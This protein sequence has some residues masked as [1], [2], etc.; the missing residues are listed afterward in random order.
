MTTPINSGETIQAGNGVATSFTITYPFFEKDDLVVKAQRT[1]DALPLTMVLG[2]DYQIVGTAVDGRFEANA[3]YVEFLEGNQV[4]S[5]VGNPAPPLATAVSITRFTD[6]DQLTNYPNGGLFPAKSHEQALDKLTKLAQEGNRVDTR[7]FK[8]DDIV[9]PIGNT[10]VVPIADQFLAFDSSLNLT[11]KGLTGLGA[12]DLD[13]VAFTGGTIDGVDIGQTTPALGDFTT[14][15]AT[16]SILADIINELT[17]DTGVTVEGV[18]MI[19]GKMTLQSL[20]A[21]PASPSEGCLWYNSTT[22]QYKGYI[23][24]SVVVFSTAGSSTTPTLTTLFPRVSPNLKPDITSDSQITIPAGF[25]IYAD[26]GSAVIQTVSSLVIDLSNPAGNLGLDTGTEAASTAY[27]IYLISG[28]SGVGAIAVVSGNTPVL[29]SGY[30][31]AKAKLPYAAINDADSNLLKQRVVSGWPNNPVIDFADETVSA[32]GIAALATGKTTL[33][34]ASTINLPSTLTV[35]CS[36]LVPTMARSVRLHTGINTDFAGAI[37]LRRFGDTNWT[38][39]PGFPNIVS[40][41]YQT[42][43]EVGL[44][45]SRRFEMSGD[46][47]SSKNLILQG[48]VITENPV[49]S[50]GLVV[51]SDSFGSIQTL[52]ADPVSPDD[53]DVWL[54]TTDNKV[55][56]RV[57]GTTKETIF[58]GDSVSFL[59]IS[60]SDVATTTITASGA[61]NLNG[62]TTIDNLRSASITKPGGSVNIEGIGHSSNYL[63]LAAASDLSG[64]GVNARNVWWNSTDDKPKA[65][66]VTST[67]TFAFESDLY[68]DGYIHGPQPHIIPDTDDNLVTQVRVPNGLTCL[69]DTNSNLITVTANL[70]VDL[71]NPNGALGLD[72]G[73]LAANQHRYLWLCEGTSGVT[74][75]LS[76]SDTSPTLPTGYTTRKRRLPFPVQGADASNLRNQE[77]VHGWPYTPYIRLRDRAAGVALSSG[78]A[79]TQTAISLSNFVPAIAAT[80]SVRTEL[81]I[82]AAGSKSAKLFRRN[83]SGAGYEVVFTETAA[84]DRNERQENWIDTDSSQNI[85]YIC[86]SADANL[87]VR[88]TGYTIQEL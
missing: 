20:S 17:T 59:N 70:D 51:A 16:G 53:G 19:D 26:D 34:A 81:S 49:Y 40:T 23:N 41:V 14:L 74:A 46:S 22:D 28:S 76:Q 88:V 18:K 36:T 85:G 43:V 1:T 84:T 77:I 42:D 37:L 25:T 71:S 35:D 73:T 15:K 69:D 24:G 45:N 66:T 55:K 31:T 32:V 58:T 56:F 50:G 79:T 78:S 86:S 63:R 29:P 67:E 27:D 62:V 65:A 64:S 6:L 61:A 47:Q 54:N 8:F 13:N 5:G 60:G 57:N 52:A 39:V 33:V 12:L 21:D 3:A 9:S 4:A 48:Y 44:D 80:V 83:G 87:D 7:S 75:V 11:V 82:T 30:N 72:A 10:E 68:P 38:T 2:T